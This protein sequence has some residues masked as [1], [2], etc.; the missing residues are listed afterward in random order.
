MDLSSLS[1]EDLM[2]LKSGD[3][4]KVSTEGLTALRGGTSGGSAPEGGV[5]KVI[6]QGA[7]NVAAGLVRGAGSIGATILAPVDMAKDALA[8]KGLS[9]DSNRQ[10]RAD[11]DATLKDF[12]AQPDSLLY[13]AGKLGG[14][15]AGTAGAGGAVANG[16]RVA[17]AAPA[18]VDAVASGGLAGG[19]NALVRAAGGAINGAA[20]AG[21]ADPQE[22]VKGGVIGGAIPGAVK[23]GGMAGSALADAAE[24][25]SR[26]LMQSAIKPTIAQRKS[27][28][29][30]TAIDTLLQYGINPTK[31]GVNKLKALVDDLNTQISGAINSSNATVDKQKVLDALDTVRTRFATQVSPTKDLNAIQGVADD[32]AAHPSLP[33]TDIP[34]QVAQDMKQG[35]YRVLSKKYGEAGSAE[36]EAQKGLARG[37]K[38]EIATAVPA[39]GPLNAEESKLLT[40]LSVAERRALL[41]ANKNP[42]GL[43]ALAH[44]PL[45]WAA[46]M[47]D[48]SAAFKSLAARMA[49]SVAAPAAAATGR[50]LGG[51][52][53]NPLL[54]SAGEMTATS[55]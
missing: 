32:F 5:S 33:G 52:A 49:Y 25:G 4:S 31:G 39:V 14:E 29:A 20:T 27:G 12:G 41:E 28:D 24:A 8:G 10:R 6:F 46:F 43:A 22:A 48:R 3:L 7:G 2:A 51:A 30:E 42:M 9:L 13:K 16:L 38:E 1:T 40:T 35:T 44:N 36:T 19:G 37:L 54:R 45:G 23:L 50:V 34:V 26:R 53:A 17:G 15:V 21:L 55:P 47:A 18:L 11:M